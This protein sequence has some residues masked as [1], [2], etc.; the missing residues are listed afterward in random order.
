MWGNLRVLVESTTLCVQMHVNLPL[1]T[2][3]DDGP[4]T[5]LIGFLLD[6]CAERNG[7]HDTITEL[8]VQD[9]LVGV[10]VVLD[11]LVESVDKGFCWGHLHLPAT[12]GEASQ[13]VF[14]D[15][16]VNVQDFCQ[17]LDVFG[18]SLSLAVEQCSDGNF[19]AP[20]SLG[21]GLEGKVLLLLGFKEGGG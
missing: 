4:V 13:L 5:L 7:T 20:E 19:F 21:D 11:N 12:V 1:A 18:G 16:L 2:E 9:S 17:V 10:T 3:S 8:L 15:G 6:L 14:E